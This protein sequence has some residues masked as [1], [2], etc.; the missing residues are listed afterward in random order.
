MPVLSQLLKQRVD[1]A[2]RRVE[3]ARQS[4]AK[5]E[6][7]MKKWEDA[8]NLELGTEVRDTKFNIISLANEITLNLNDARTK[9]GIVKAALE[10]ARRPITP[11]ELIELVKPAISRSM[12]YNIVNEM[13]RTEEIKTDGEGRIELAHLEETVS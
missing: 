2:R 3:E 7:K 13:K 12:V 1:Q 4:L 6:A 5:E 8:L 11:S 10:K 9:A